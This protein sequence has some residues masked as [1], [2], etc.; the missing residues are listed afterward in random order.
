VTLL[1]IRYPKVHEF[2]IMSASETPATNPYSSSLTAHYAYMVHQTA[3]PIAPARYGEV[4]KVVFYASVRWA[5]TSS[6]A[7]LRVAPMATGANKTPDS[8]TLPPSSILRVSGANTAWSFTA[9]DAAQLFDAVG[10]TSVASLPTSTQQITGATTLLSI[11][12][13]RFDAGSADFFAVW[14]SVAGT[15]QYLGFRIVVERMDGSNAGVATFADVGVTVVQAP[16]TSN[17][18]VTLIPLTVAYIIGA[19]MSKTYGSFRSRLF[20]YVAANWDNITEATILTRCFWTNT[21]TRTFRVGLHKL[22]TYEPATFDLLYEEQFADNTSRAAGDTI[23]CRT[24]DVKGYLVDGADH[25]V[26]YED[27]TSAGNRDEPES[28][29]EIV[30]E[31]FTL[32]ECHHDGGNQYRVDTTPTLYGSPATP[33]FDPVWYQS[34]PDSLILSRA[35]FLAF[36]HLSAVANTTIRLHIDAN[37]ESNIT[38]L[39]GTSATIAGINPQ[40]N[41]TP[42]AT[43]GCKTRSQT[44]SPDPIDLAGQRKMVF[45]IVIGTGAGTDD[46][47]GTTELIYALYVPA[48]EVPEIGDVF[49]LGEFNPECCASTAAGL[50][51]PGLLILSNGSTLPKKFDP[52]HEAIEDAGIPAPFCDEALPTSQ[53]DDTAASPSGG[54]GAGTYY[55]RYTFRNCCTNKESD[56]NDT[57]ILVDTSGASPAAQVTLNFTNVRIPGDPQICEIC[58]YRTVLDAGDVTVMAKVGCFDPDTTSTFVDDVADSALDFTNDGL[59]LLNAPPPCV[60]ILAEFRNRIFGM[61]DIPD[62]SPAGTVSVVTGSNIVTGDDNVQ[63]TR[64]MEGK[65]IQLEGDCRAYEIACVMPPLAGESPPLGRL[66][67][68]D[69]YAGSDQTGALYTICGRPNRLW[70]SEPLEPEY[71]PA[72]N[73]LDVESGDGDRLMGAISNFDSLVI[74]KRR[75][76]YVLRFS[77]TPTEVNVPSRISSDIGCIAPRSFAQVESGSVWLS[78]RGLCLYDGRSV[79]MI[80]ESVMFDS[81]FTDPDNAN[82]VRRDSEGRVIGA[83][84]VYYPKRQ[85]YLLLLPTVQTVRGA[86]L[87]MVWDTQ[88]RNV[89]V[90]KFCQEFLAMTV[91]KDSDGNERVYLGD[92][93]GFVWLLD[94]GD[95]DGVGSPGQTGTTSGVITDAGIDSLGASFIEDT[96]ASFIEGGLPALAG[97]SGVAGLSAAFAG[98]DLGL[99]GACVFYRASDAAPDDPWESRTI[100]AATQTK[101]YVTPSFTTDAPPQGYD[102]LIGAIDFRAEFKPTNFGD[103]DLL[104]RPWRQCIVHEPETVT[105][106]VRVELIPDF[107]NSDD[108]EGSVVDA[109]GQIGQGRVFDMNFSKGRQLQPVG[110]QLYNFEQ[111][112]LTNFAPESPIRLLNHL[113]MVDAHTSK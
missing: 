57:G 113:M 22:G 62:L 78:D 59:S 97:L 40:L 60:P 102:Y 3:I 13:D 32:T 45:G 11:E 46:L 24:A 84:G 8:I 88:L 25:C 20:R 68:V 48:R 74:C 109:Q 76:T 35:V 108:E 105:S 69:P 52:Q 19:T 58:V 17:R 37:L 50:G 30:Q 21:G 2:A 55:Y 6:V 42:T 92:T 96:T 23:L 104:K 91:G 31:D 36:S 83:V 93:N 16:S 18:S 98:D 70:F 14:D 9:F 82:Y 79:A 43:V 28:W 4:R 112:V 1:G 103:D 81:Y 44:P 71:W 100:F 56:P 75:K 95:S 54:L 34:F 106:L 72:A 89:T 27:Q 64:C 110:R 41:A 86:N 73:F 61:G 63:W 90:W 66:K 65:Y 39:S 33:L 85:Q 87:L 99:A 107:Q 38:G 12:F 67:L 80:P 7:R 51:D 5:S 10:D 47:V 101:L 15:D 77:D 49:E 111:I 94:I 53:V 29:L 26:L